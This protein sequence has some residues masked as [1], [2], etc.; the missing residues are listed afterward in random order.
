MKGILAADCT[1]IALFLSSTQ[2]TG[3]Q[4]H[5][6][7]TRSVQQIQSSTLSQHSQTL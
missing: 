7:E 4:R 3:L 5:T 1:Q 6:A 2:F